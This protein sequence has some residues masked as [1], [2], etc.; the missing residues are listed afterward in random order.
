[1]NLSAHD[2]H[3]TLMM[4]QVLAWYFTTVGYIWMHGIKDGAKKTYA[5]GVWAVLSGIAGYLVGPD[6]FRLP[7][8]NDLF[9]TQAVLIPILL[10]LL[11]AGKY[12]LDGVPKE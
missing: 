11:T 8:D 5:S 3:V 12:A 2:W 9:F 1:M 7:L 4:A 6:V 10:V